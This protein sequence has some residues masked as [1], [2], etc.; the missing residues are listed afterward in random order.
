M[1]ERQA[2]Y[3]T[4]LIAALPTEERFSYVQVNGSGGTSQYSTLVD[5]VASVCVC[6]DDEA[7]VMVD[8]LNELGRRRRA[9]NEAQTAVKVLEKKDRCNGRQ[10]IRGNGVVYA[11]H[12][13]GVECPFHGLH[14]DESKRL[15]KYVGRDVEKIEAFHLA[16]SDYKWWQMAQEDLRVCKLNVEKL[17]ARV[18]SLR[19][20]GEG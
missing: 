7:A 13:A 16:M 1:S 11:V 14:D 12:T 8:V 4:G 2:E 17:S 6:L 10:E 5:L 3:V 18:L 9:V 20:K 19:A 15:A